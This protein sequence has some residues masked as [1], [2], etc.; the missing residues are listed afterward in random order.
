MEKGIGFKIE[1]HENVLLVKD[2]FINDSMRGCG[3]II[4]EQ[5]IE[6]SSYTISDFSL[7]SLLLHGE[8]VYQDKKVLS[9]TYNDVYQ[10]SEYKE[11]FEKARD[12][13]NNSIGAY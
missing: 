12:K 3:E 7:R 2:I 6:I 8:N 5:G 1:Q 4:K 9:Y 10:A 11:A 13:Y